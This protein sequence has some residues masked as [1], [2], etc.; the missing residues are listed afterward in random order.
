M[1]YFLFATNDRIILRRQIALIISISSNSVYFVPV[2]TQYSVTVLL[3]LGLNF[4]TVIQFDLDL[5]TQGAIELIHYLAFRLY[6]P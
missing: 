6:S 2:S 4:L 3:Y 1:Y 5:M